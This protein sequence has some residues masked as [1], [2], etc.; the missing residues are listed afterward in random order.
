V[1]SRIVVVM[2]AV[3]VVM[4][5]LGGGCSF[6]MTGPPA[7]PPAPPDCQR[8]RFP[9]IADIGIAFFGLIGTE[10]SAGGGSLGER[11]N[12]G[13]AFFI[14][15][16]AVSTISS[17]YGFVRTGQCRDAYAARVGTPSYVPPPPPGSVPGAYP[18]P[19]PPFAP[20]PQ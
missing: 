3:V 16:M 1:D 17:V 6:I 15:L 10:I 2:R 8:S 14:P 18:P 4:M 19:P 5:L 13:L 7:A 11:S 20:P 9:P 12:S